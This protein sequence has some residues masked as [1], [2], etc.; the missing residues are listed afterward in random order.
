MVLHCIGLVIGNGFLFS[1]AR[2]DEWNP[3]YVCRVNSYVSKGVQQS[4]VLAEVSVLEGGSSGRSVWRSLRGSF[5][6]SFRACFAGTFRQK[7]LQQKHQ[8]KNSH[9]SAQ[10][11]GGIS[12]KNFMTRFCRGTLANGYGLFCSHSSGDAGLTLYGFE[13][14]PFLN[15]FGE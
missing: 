13:C 11:I 9:D 7:K 4:E 2:I 8:P 6:R 12:G 1:K 15:A 14:V 5:S 3:K 10:Q